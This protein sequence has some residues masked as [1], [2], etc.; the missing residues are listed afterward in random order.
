MSFISGI[1][2]HKVNSLQTARYLFIFPR[3]CE[4]LSSFFT[5]LTHMMQAAAGSVRGL[6][7]HNSPAGFSQHL[8]LLLLVHERG[9][10]HGL[11]VGDSY[12]GQHSLKE[13]GEF[14]LLA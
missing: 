8:P 2:L 5:L 6:R 3:F 1:L 4:S 14:G 13:R 11:Q 12:S 7:Q 9:G 10:Q